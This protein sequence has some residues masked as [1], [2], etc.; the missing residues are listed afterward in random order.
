MLGASCRTRVIKHLA[1][2]FN[3]LSE[4][5]DCL[6]ID[7]VFGGDELNVRE[8]CQEDKSPQTSPL[9]DEVLSPVFAS[10]PRVSADDEFPL[11]I[12]DIIRKF[13]ACF[14]RAMSYRLKNQLLN[15]LFKLVV[16]DTGG[17]D[18]FNFVNPDFI[19]TS[20]NAM[21]VLHDEKKHNLILKLCQCFQ[22]D[23][24]KLSTRMPMDK[25][26]FGMIDYNVRFFASSQTRKIIC[27]EHYACWLE[28]MF[29]HFGHKWL[30][31]HRG[32]V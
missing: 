7:Y 6:K 12:G 16:M 27:E 19:Q 10:S 3:T 31:L 18:L 26:P 25:M 30:C 20:L 15:Y 9:V 17:I 13:V 23:E 14:K 29:A 21:N 11:H 32:P 1:K 24:S 28:T 5:E 4:A 2:E 22:M 8:E